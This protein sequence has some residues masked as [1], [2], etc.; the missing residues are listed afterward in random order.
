MFTE[1]TK[2]ASGMFVVDWAIN[3]PAWRAWREW[4]REVF[5]KKSFPQKLTTQFAWPPESPTGAQTV[6]DYLSGIR[7][8]IE[9]EDRKHGGGVCKAIPD[10][11][12]PWRGWTDEQRADVSADEVQRRQ[13]WGS[14]FA[15][16]PI[17]ATRHRTGFRHPKPINDNRVRTVTTQFAAE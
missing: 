9:K 1:P 5:G 7:K 16:A 6:A 3:Y 4:L 14:L 13:E 10:I 11:I 12:T 8:E 17:Y 2:T 15:N